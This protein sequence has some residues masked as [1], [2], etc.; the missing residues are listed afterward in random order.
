MSCMYEAHT[1]A[2]GPRMLVT[3]TEVLSSTTPP[4]TTGVHGGYIATPG[5]YLRTV[6]CALGA[7][8]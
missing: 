2:Y 4:S 1:G 3:H 7:R 8:Q 5:A 6:R